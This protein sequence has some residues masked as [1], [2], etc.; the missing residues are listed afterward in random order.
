MLSVPGEKVF[1]FTSV[2]TKGLKVWPSIMKAKDLHRPSRWRLPVE[3][4]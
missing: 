2:S 4:E 3:V 1:A